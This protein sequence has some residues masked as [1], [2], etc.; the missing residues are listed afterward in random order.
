MSKEKSTCP[1]CGA[2]APDHVCPVCSTEAEVETEVAAT[3]AVDGEK[4]NS[5]SAGR[6]GSE[7]S[8]VEWLQRELPDYELIRELG[9]GGMGRVFLAKHIPL[10]R[11]VAIKILSVKLSAQEDFL[12]R[13]LREAQAMAKLVHGNIVQI[14][15]YGENEHSCYIIMEYVEGSNLLELI[16][17]GKLE[18]E[19]ALAIVSQIC[20]ALQFAHECG[21][22][23]RD[24]KP[25]NVMVSPTGQVKVADFGLA[26]LLSE[27]QNPD[28][29]LTLTGVVMGTPAYMAPE[30]LKSVANVDNRADIYSLGIMF[31]EMLTGQRPAGRVEAPSNSNRQLN[32]SID[33]IVLKAMEAE[34]ERRYQQAVNMKTDIEQTVRI[35]HVPTKVD[36]RP[37]WFALLCVLFLVA[38]LGVWVGR[39]YLSRGGN[40]PVALPVEQNAVTSLEEL[41]PIKVELEQL[42]E[43]LRVLERSEG[44]GSR[45][46][47]LERQI[48]SGQA[49]FEQ[50]SPEGAR[51]AFEQ[52]ISEAKSLEA[53]EEER[54]I[55]TSRLGDLEGLATFE[56]ERVAKASALVSLAGQQEKLARTA[57][58]SGEFGV[59]EEFIA[60]ASKLYTRARTEIENAESVEAAH[61]GFDN[62]L[63]AEVKP[64]LS[65]YGGA[66]WDLLRQRIAENLEQTPANAIKEIG[67]LRTELSNLITASRAKA[68]TARLEM[69]MQQE[70]AEARVKWNA[71]IAPHSSLLTQYGGVEWETLLERA[72]DDSVSDIREA[73]QSLPVVVRL[74][75]QRRDSA[76]HAK[77]LADARDFKS[78][79]EWSRVQL[80]VER[81]LALDVS[82]Q[83]EAETLLNEAKA[84]LGPPGGTTLSV[85]VNGTARMEFVWVPAGSFKMG[86]PDSEPNRELD[87]T[88]HEVSI[89][90]GFWMGKYELT[91]EQYQAVTGENPSIFKGSDLPVENITSRDAIACAEKMQF[92]TKTEYASWRIRLPTEAE[93]EY[94]CRAGADT[95]TAFGNS[96]SSTQANF[97]GLSP[98]NGG[99][100]GPALG[101]TVK[102][103]SYL[104][105]AWGLHDMHGNVRE[106]CLDW[107]AEDFYTRSPKENPHQSSTTRL[108]VV[109]GG[110]WNEFGYDCRSGSRDAIAPTF[111]GHFTGVR[112]V[113]A[114]MQAP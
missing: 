78:K 101:R 35:V 25:G 23:H 2:E 9:A 54:R 108:R 105:N 106:W 96:L 69:A 76:S 63:T 91:Q 89:E 90:R 27:D 100:K 95:A 48:R 13:F 66:E 75:G 24:I 94:A 39:D 82:D 79:E 56:P 51:S 65:E 92:L 57:F 47:R 83:S 68:T 40:D 112:L 103:G 26:K 46:D 28:D 30:Q 61:R 17:G 110:G 18:P 15:D 84:R 80:V 104:P 97:R 4:N 43:R 81:A 107:Y 33:E 19:Q 36:K 55:L 14:Y 87:E 59:A 114:P 11:L 52:A 10:D 113:L 8:E 3:K 74:A 99:D 85:G 22:I 72:S 7:G 38:V 111:Q 5:Q 71:A 109:R 34:P 58:A 32:E 50:G 44:F 60:S 29:S 45:L 16:R 49:L 62:M 77:M 53:S 93:W 37:V 88:P 67:A 31:Y 86:T 73:T 70:V 1:N 21:V 12:R 42:W 102:V 64:L 41:V 98:Y 6:S 20:D